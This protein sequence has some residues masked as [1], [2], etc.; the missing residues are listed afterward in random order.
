MATNKTTAKKATAAAA[1]TTATTYFC[2]S[3]GRDGSIYDYDVCTAADLADFS[4]DYQH[5]IKIT[6][7]IMGEEGMLQIVGEVKVGK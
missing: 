2:F 5:A 4:A 7:P 6:T 1:P 3:A